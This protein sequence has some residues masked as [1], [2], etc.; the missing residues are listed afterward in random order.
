MDAEKKLEYIASKAD[1]A[2]GGVDMIERVG[3][4]LPDGREAKDL[5]MG[6][7]RVARS[8][9]LIRTCTILADFDPAVE[10]A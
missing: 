2:M 6:L 10:E 8:L 5:R 3:R 4:A 9:R 7:F 1:E